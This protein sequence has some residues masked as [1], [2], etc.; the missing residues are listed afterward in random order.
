MMQIPL[1]DAQAQLPSIIRGL[2]PDEELL[3]TSND[4]PIARLVGVQR[5]QKPL[6]RRLGTSIGKLRIISEDDEHLSD[7][8]EY[9]S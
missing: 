2:Q 9:M 8:A 5:R 6:R 7:F 1:S 4:E 3:I